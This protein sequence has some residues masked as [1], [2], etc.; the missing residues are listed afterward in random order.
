MN[1]AI[2]TDNQLYLNNMFQTNPRFQ[3]GLKLEGNNLIYELDNIKDQVDISEFYIPEIFYND[4]LRNEVQNNPEFNSLDLFQT[5]KVAVLIAD[6]KKLEIDLQ[7]ETLMNMKPVVEQPAV[8]DINNLEPVISEPTV[9]ETVVEEP[10][11]E[12]IIPVVETPSPVNVMPTIPRIVQDIVPETPEVNSELEIPV[13]NEPIVATPEVETPIVEPIIE[14]VSVE[15]VKPLLPYILEMKI[16]NQDNEEVVIF[17]DNQNKHYKMRTK[18]PQNIIN[19]Y[20]D[21]KNKQTYI[22]IEDWKIALEGMMR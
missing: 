10:I 21:L 4:Q 14:S 8:D 12:P 13:I 16:A 15:P 1:S 22:T 18:N 11:T 19:L 5:I 3:I 17:T 7:N 9:N 2:M 20:N 6:L